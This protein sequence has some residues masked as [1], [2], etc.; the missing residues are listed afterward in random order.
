MRKAD[1]ASETLLDCGGFRFY[2][3]HIEIDKHGFFGGFKGVDVIYYSDIAG[4][5]VRG[6]IMDVKKAAMKN[7]I[8]LRFRNRKQAQEGLSII[9][10]HKA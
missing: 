1:I 5:S 2:D 9:N 6:S 8:M 4:I 7:V 3:N 10:T